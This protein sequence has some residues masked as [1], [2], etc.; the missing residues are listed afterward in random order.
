MLGDVIE[1]LRPLTL[2]PVWVVIRLCTN[3]VNIVNFWN[4]ID[5]QIELDMDVI[6]DLVGKITSNCVCLSDYYGKDF[7]H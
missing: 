4:N 2:L 3:E 7:S 5:K 1:A 6:D